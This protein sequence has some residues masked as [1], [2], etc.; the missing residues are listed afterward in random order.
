MK[1]WKAESTKLDAFKRGLQTM[2][3][4]DQPK[5]GKG[6]TWACSM[7]MS[8]DDVCYNPLPDR[9]QALQ[10]ARTSLP[11]WG[12]SPGIHELKELLVQKR[13][14]DSLSL[15]W[16][17]ILLIKDIPLL[18]IGSNLLNSFGFSS[19]W[20]I[21]SKLW[22]IFI[23]LKLNASSPPNCCHQY[24]LTYLNIKHSPHLSS[25]RDLFVRKWWKLVKK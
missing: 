21:N 25:Y 3:Q 18:G 13:T 20:I 14:P 23:N 4:A 12:V 1:W 2:A 10:D 15:F 8:R 9:S 19:I 17:Y 24:P 22:S 5:L 11:F 6:A 16:Y 7:L